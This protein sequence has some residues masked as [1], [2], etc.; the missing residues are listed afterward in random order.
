MPAIDRYFKP[1]SILENMPYDNYEKFKPNQI[2]ILMILSDEEGHPQWEISERTGIATSNLSPIIRELK[3][4]DVV[5]EGEARPT[6]NPKSRHPN[7]KEYP[8]Y[9]NKEWEVYQA[10]VLSI[11]DEIEENIHS[12]FMATR[13][14]ELMGKLYQHKR[15]ELLVSTKGACTVDA[16]KGLY[17]KYE[18]LALYKGHEA[19]FYKKRTDK[20]MDYI[21]KFIISPYTE[22][23][24]KKSGFKSVFNINISGTLDIWYRETITEV[25]FQRKLITEEDYLEYYK[26][27]W[28]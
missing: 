18:R 24:I 10:I 25:A 8:L 1:N 11:H 6:T 23:M 5:Y 2:E 12:E 4:I 26:L 27:S 17:E 19:P 14:S 20:Y 16:Q 22:C 28:N 13:Q 21:E 15:D 7:T 3:E 9:I